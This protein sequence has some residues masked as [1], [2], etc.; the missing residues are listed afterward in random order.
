MRSL[1]GD[2]M[3]W[4]LGALVGPKKVE[5]MQLAAL[6]LE[7]TTKQIGQDESIARLPGTC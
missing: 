5:P 7:K 2:V 6:L 3:K 1:R 4:L